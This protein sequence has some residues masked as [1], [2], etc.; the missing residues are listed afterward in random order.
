MKGDFSLPEAFQF[1]LVL[2]NTYYL[3]A[4]LGHGYRVGG[5]KVPKSNDS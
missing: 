2:L 3:V 5:P 1:G 4:Q